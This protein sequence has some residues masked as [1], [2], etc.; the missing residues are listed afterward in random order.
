MC[1]IN[2]EDFSWP[3][4][5]D[6]DSEISEQFS[7]CTSNT[8]FEGDVDLVWDSVDFNERVDSKHWKLY[9]DTDSYTSV[10][11]IR[12]RHQKD[13]EPVVSNLVIHHKH[14]RRK[15][16]HVARYYCYSN[17]DNSKNNPFLPLWYPQNKCY[18]QWTGELLSSVDHS[19]SS[20]FYCV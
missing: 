7:S 2:C 10:I 17:Y 19:C 1:E 20:P 5:S 14:E 4:G 13:D 6:S 16:G 9:C 11:Q 8:E 18:I 3:V 15:S 12:D